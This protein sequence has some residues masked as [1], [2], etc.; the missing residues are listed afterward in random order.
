[1]QDNQA[2]SGILEKGGFKP[3]TSSFL[4]AW[5]GIAYL[6]GKCCKMTHDGWHGHDVDQE[7]SQEIVG[8]LSRNHRAEGEKSIAR[9]SRSSERYHLKGLLKGFLTQTESQLQ[10]FVLPQCKRKSCC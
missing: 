9:V 5:T 6:R 1:M 10:L 7:G 8:K 2:H 4:L 3:V